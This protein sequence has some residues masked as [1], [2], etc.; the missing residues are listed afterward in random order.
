MRRIG[1]WILLILF[2]GLLV[3]IFVAKF[4]LAESVM[5]YVTVVVAFVFSGGFRKT[6]AYTSR[7][8]VETEADDLNEDELNESEETD[9]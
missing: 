9:E 6:A 7:Q 1:A 3:N 4:Y 2:F 5:V 8:T